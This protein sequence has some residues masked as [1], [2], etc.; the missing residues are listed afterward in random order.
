MSQISTGRWTLDFG[1]WT[2]SDHRAGAPPACVVDEIQEDV[3]R[4]CAFVVRPIDEHRAPDDQVAR[5][6]AQITTVGA[7]VAVVAHNE[8]TVG[9][10]GAE[11]GVLEGSII[12][13]VVIEALRRSAL[14]RG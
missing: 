8:V 6:E 3:R 12:V 7:V 14:R 9:S 13:A 2:L 10:A 11:V 4:W 5:H 1:L